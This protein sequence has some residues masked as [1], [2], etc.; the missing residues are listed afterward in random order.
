MG[1]SATA[2]KLQESSNPDNRTVNSSEEFVTLHQMWQNLLNFDI[3]WCH[4]NF[5]NKT[6][7]KTTTT[8][9]SLFNHGNVLVLLCDTQISITLCFYQRHIEDREICVMI[10]VCSWLKA[11]PTAFPVCT[12]F[13]LV[14]TMTFPSFLPR[15]LF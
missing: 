13:R 14:V 4:N 2:G 11:L 6:K 10:P 15:S 8:N 5:F 12:T 9:K 7:V 1:S 3:I